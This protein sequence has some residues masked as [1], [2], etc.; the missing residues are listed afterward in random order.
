[1]ELALAA[2][3]VHAGSK[4]FLRIVLKVAG[5]KQFDHLGPR[6]VR[7]RRETY[8]LASERGLTRTLR[9]RP[10]SHRSS[11]IVLEK[12]TLNEWI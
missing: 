12:K 1:M 2:E 6:E 3:E 4:V 5:E 7:Y 9:R 10:L 11:F 8:S